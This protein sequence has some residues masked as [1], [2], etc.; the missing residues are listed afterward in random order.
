MSALSFSC[1]L[2]LIRVE[3]KM[4]NELLSFCITTFYFI[5]FY[6][7]KLRCNNCLSFLSMFSLM[8]ICLIKQNSVCC[9]PLS[10]SNSIYS[11]LYYEFE[12]P[13]VSFASSIGYHFH[14][15]FILTVS[16]CLLCMKLS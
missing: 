12:N 10:F 2:S 9:G 8:R 3:K 15:S 1:Y 14:S 5:R 16:P 4:H 13:F 6:Q 11:F 7:R